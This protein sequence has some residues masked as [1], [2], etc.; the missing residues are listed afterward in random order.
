[1]YARPNLLTAC[2]LAVVEREQN[3]LT[4]NTSNYCWRKGAEQPNA[5]HYKLL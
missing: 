3:D 5:Q 4:D 1:M 2:D